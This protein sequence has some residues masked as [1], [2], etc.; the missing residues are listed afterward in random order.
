MHKPNVV[1][2]IDPYE[3][4]VSLIKDQFMYGG[5]KYA[6]NNKKEVTDILFYTYGY[7][8]LLGTMD[9][10]TYRYSNL[11]REK[12][13]LKIACYTYILWLKR[14]FHL[15]REGEQSIINTKVKVKEKYFSRFLSRKSENDIYIDKY[16][17]ISN[18]I[19]YISKLIT[20]MGN[21]AI[22]DN[23]WYDI[24]ELDLFLIFS[25]AYSQWV[26][27]SWHLNHTHDTDTGR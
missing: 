4:F 3:L 9:K 23:A 14:G 10:Y 2:K 25:K 8:W 27:D 19:L 6:F 16:P 1:K 7:K 20:E 18:H 11:K 26:K 5:Q 17:K 12:D 24:T 13:L 15:N 21:E 22:S